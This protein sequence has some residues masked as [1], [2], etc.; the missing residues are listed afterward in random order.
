MGR[1]ARERRFFYDSNKVRTRDLY[2][3]STVKHFL[4]I[5]NI[6]YLKLNLACRYDLYFDSFWT[7]SV[8]LI[9]ENNE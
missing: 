2:K 9:Q 1:K 8:S 6:I 4:L 7:D 3:L 5:C